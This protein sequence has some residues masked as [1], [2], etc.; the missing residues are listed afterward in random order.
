MSKKN[1]NSFALVFKLDG[2]FTHES[3]FKQICQL[4]RFSH[5]NEERDQRINMIRICKSCSALAL[6]IAGCFRM[7]Y[8]L[9]NLHLL[10]FSHV[11]E[12]GDRD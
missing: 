10:G 11:N 8:F 9:G 7:S 3:F 1:E 12:N 6:E 2:Y 5:V 4:Q